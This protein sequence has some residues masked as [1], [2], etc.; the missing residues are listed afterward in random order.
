MSYPQLPMVFRWYMWNGLPFSRKLYYSLGLGGVDD[1]NPKW[2]EAPSRTGRGRFHKYLVELNL[3]QAVEREFYFLG[4]HYERDLQLLLD[5]ILRPGDT[6]ID[7]GA[8]LGF[9]TLHAAS[10]VGP[11]G[12]VIAFEPQSACCARIARLIDINQI[13]HIEIH[14]VGLSDKPGELTLKLPGGISALATFAWDES[15]DGPEVS[16]TALVQLLVADDVVRDRIIG[17]LMIKIDVE[18]FELFVIRGLDETIRRHRPPMFIE[19]QPSNL[20]RAGV[21]VEQ[22][23]E[24]FHERNYRGHVVTV[25]GRWK[26]RRVRLRAM[27]SA[28]DLYEGQAELKLSGSEQNVLW[29]PADGSR[30]D[31][32]PYLV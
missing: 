17:N 13:K 19:M 15:V 8:N 25:T 6:F 11:G 10:R 28:D 18:G 4:Y 22:I 31:P 32:S 20:R 7:V 24:F 5:A 2:R 3:S 21:T 16:N 27:A 14:N 1:E 26:Y 9:V 30:F 29:L 23:F 12:R